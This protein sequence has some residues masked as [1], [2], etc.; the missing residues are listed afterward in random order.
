MENK[1]EYIGINTN[2]IKS[3]E[4]SKGVVHDIKIT[5]T[6]ISCLLYN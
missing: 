5:K 2:L 4:T 1:L 3:T 6:D